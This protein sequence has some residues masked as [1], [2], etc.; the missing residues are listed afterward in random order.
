MSIVYAL[1]AL[2]ACVQPVLALGTGKAVAAK[3][4]EKG[5]AKQ[6]YER[7][8]DRSKAPG[9]AGDTVAYNA[10]LNKRFA[11]KFLQSVEQE[12]MPYAVAFV[13]AVEAVH[14]GTEVDGVA[15]D[16]DIAVAFNLLDSMVAV[17]AKNPAYAEQV[18]AASNAADII[19]TLLVCGADNKVLVQKLLSRGLI[20]DALAK[21][22]DLQ[23][24][25]VKSLAKVMA[26]NEI[27][28]EVFSK[29]VGDYQVLI[30]NAGYLSPEFKEAA[31]ASQA[32]SLELMER[33]AFP[34]M[35][36]PAVA[37]MT[38]ALAK[39]VACGVEYESLVG[40]LNAMDTFVAENSNIPESGKQYARQV[41][42]LVRQF[43][44]VYMREL[45]LVKEATAKGDTTVLRK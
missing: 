43:A 17:G 11:A 19:V 24:R 10:P 31:C 16:S 38:S 36:N 44:A 25:G 18:A 2:V 15:V 1:V 34:S 22:V 39:M 21:D 9:V 37:A 23:L 26:L 42:A 7:L 6:K 30:K 12:N 4:K 13:R 20:D 5:S 32:V 29:L 27:N 41:V 14:N 45:T 35:N 33:Y 8:E 3:V 28:G 40:M